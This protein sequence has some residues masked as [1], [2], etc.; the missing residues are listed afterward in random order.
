MLCARQRRFRERLCEISWPEAT[1]FSFRNAKRSD[2]AEPICL[3]ATDERGALFH[4]ATLLNNG[5]I[6]IVGGISPI[7]GGFA[8][9]DRAELFD[10][11]TGAFTAVSSM[12]SPRDSHTAT[13]LP[14]GKVLIAG[15]LLRTVNGN[16]SYLRT[17]ELFDPAT[18]T[19]ASIASMGSARQLHTATLLRNGKV[20]IVGGDTTS[21]DG[22][23]KTAELF[24]PAT[25]TFTS[26]G[27]STLSEPRSSHTATLLSSGK[28]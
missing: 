28:F 12:T 22:T 13:L 10:P 20:L 25:A 21:V 8:S 16:I 2:N 3:S 24:D 7:T 9:T 17:A 14:N 1:S 19:F 11:A 27:L 15:G 4:T 26:L 5:K 18:G 23:L 6:L